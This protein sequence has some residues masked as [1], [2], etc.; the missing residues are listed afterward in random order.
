RALRVIALYRENGLERTPTDPREAQG[1]GRNG[2]ARI[3]PLRNSAKHNERT[4]SAQIR[5]LIKRELAVKMSSPT[6]HDLYGRNDPGSALPQSRN[7][8]RP[9][10]RGNSP[11]HT[12]IASPLPHPP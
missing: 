12:G 4:M 2:R 5:Y 6:A 3:P 10:L 11:R 1:H 8:E 7:P 9:V